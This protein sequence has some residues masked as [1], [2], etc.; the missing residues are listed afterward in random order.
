M[1][2][3][4]PWYNLLKPG[5][6][7]VNMYI[8][9][10]CRQRTGIKGLWEDQVSLKL[11][12]C[13]I[14]TILQLLRTAIY[15]VSLVSYNNRIDPLDQ[16]EGK[17]HFNRHGACFCPRVDSLYIAIYI[18]NTFLI[19]RRL[20]L[21]THWT[22]THNGDTYCTYLDNG[23]NVRWHPWILRCLNPT[24]SLKTVRSPF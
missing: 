13:I 9:M 24:P 1:L 16:V 2:H 14:I 22:Y 23:Q 5:L 20:Q 8:Y 19:S 21:H 4:N 7:Y 10:T 11:E 18:A 15:I 17:Q 12:V 3:V 6:N